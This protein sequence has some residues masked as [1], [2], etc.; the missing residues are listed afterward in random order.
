[1][2]TYVL[3]F[4]YLR[5]LCWLGVIGNKAIE[6][7]VKCL[8]SPVLFGLYPGKLHVLLSAMVRCNLIGFEQH[9]PLRQ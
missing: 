4:I 2:F 5:S 9:S 8:K 1:M 3:K 6:D 7:E